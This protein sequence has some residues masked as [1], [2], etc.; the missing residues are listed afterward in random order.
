MNFWKLLRWAAALVVAAV[1]LLAAW[2]APSDAPTVPL[3]PGIEIR[4]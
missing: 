4:P 1:A 3:R 2:L